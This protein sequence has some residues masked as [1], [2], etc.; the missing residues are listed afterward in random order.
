MPANPVPPGKCPLNE[1]WTLFCRQQLKLSLSVEVEDGLELVEKMAMDVLLLGKVNL[2]WTV[3]KDVDA[4][5]LDA[6]AKVCV[7]VICP[8]CS[9]Q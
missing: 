8:C 6:V 3:E 1:W 5:T 9:F 2:P 7:V 4:L